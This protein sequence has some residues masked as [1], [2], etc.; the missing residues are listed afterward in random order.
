MIEGM[1]TT[2]EQAAEWAAE[3][4][5]LLWETM[6][7]PYSVVCVLLRDRTRALAEIER[8]K[9]AV[10]EWGD[11]AHRQAAEVA[12]LKAEHQIYHDNQWRQLQEAQAE[13]ARPNERIAEHEAE[14]ARLTRRLRDEMASREQRAADGW[15]E[16]GIPTQEAAA[17]IGWRAGAAAM[18]RACAQLAAFDPLKNAAAI[19]AA[20]RALPIPAPPAEEKTP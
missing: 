17:R 13:I 19:A 3:A 6:E 8:L 20:I 12:R 16:D 15:L 18:R 5:R 11:A 4:D 9:T 14:I 7:G 2:D 1:E 10:T